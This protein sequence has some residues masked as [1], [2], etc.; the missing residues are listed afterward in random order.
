MN[1]TG[2]LISFEGIDGCGKS[3]QLGLLHDRLLSMSIPTLA[4]REPG[5]TPT[6][7]AIRSILLDKQ[8]D[9]SPVAEMLLF[10][11]ARAQL[12]NERI[13]PALDN[14][15]VVLLDRFFDS[16]TAYQGYGRQFMDIKTIEELNRIATG[17]LTPDLSFYFDLDVEAA[18]SRRTGQA[19]RMEDSGKDFYNRVR[20]GYVSLSSEHQERFRTIDARQS[21][22]LIQ[23]LV[24]DHFQALWQK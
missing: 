6:S 15:M 13:R 4:L 8:F 23:E 12:V 14:G 18:F 9:I 22:E 20:R 16:T 10:S 24:W 5:G 7:E 3:T 2:L 21:M 19:D 1:K 17:G 11:A